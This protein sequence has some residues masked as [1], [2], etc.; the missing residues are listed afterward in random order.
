MCPKR[1]FPFPEARVDADTHRLAGFRRVV[2]DV[3]GLKVKLPEAMQKCLAYFLDVDRSLRGY[4]GLIGKAQG[5]RYESRRSKSWVKIKAVNGFARFDASHWWQLFGRA[6]FMIRLAAGSSFAPN[7]QG[8]NWARA[9]WLTS[10]DNLRG[11]FPLDTGYLVGLHYFVSNAE[12]QFPLAPVLRLLI[13]DYLEGV[14]AADFGGVANHLKDQRQFA[15]AL[16]G[17][18]GLVTVP[19]LW[20]SRTLTLVLGVNAVLGPLLLR[21][22]FGH[23]FDIGAI[24]TPAMSDGTRW[25]TNVTLRFAFF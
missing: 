6:N 1:L 5:S 24:Q 21:V 8:R 14:V 13:F 25:V 17:I 16:D 20:S 4:E 12:L 19:G 3:I 7:D 22:H 18:C 23:P 9:W 10:A 11:Y 2:S 15:C